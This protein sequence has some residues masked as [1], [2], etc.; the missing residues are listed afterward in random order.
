MKL[1]L[2]GCNQEQLKKRNLLLDIIQF[3][4]WAIFLFFFLIFLVI[5]Y[6][7]KQELDLFLI[8]LVLFVVLA[9]F[10]SWAEPYW[11]VSKKNEKAEDIPHLQRKFFSLKKHKEGDINPLW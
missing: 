2:K 11:A 8:S 9:R 6:F 7:D 5:A 3:M 1:F 10:E 4:L